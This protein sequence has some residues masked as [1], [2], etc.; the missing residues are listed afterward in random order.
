MKNHYL[1]KINCLEV[2]VLKISAANYFTALIHKNN[3]YEK[4]YFIVQ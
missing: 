3:V 1:S 2:L 4:N